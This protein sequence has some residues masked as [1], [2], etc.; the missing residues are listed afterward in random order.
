MEFN[1][2]LKRKPSSLLTPTC[3]VGA[4]VEIPLEQFQQLINDPLGNRDY[5]REHSSAM[6]QDG[7]QYH[8]LLVLSEDTLDGVLIEA[9]GYDH[10]QYGAY[11]SGA[12]LVLKAEL[13]QV[14]DR[15]IYVG[16]EETT[17]GRWL[18]YNNR[19]DIE[20]GLTVSET[21]GI[22]NMLLEKLKQRPE[23]DDATLTDWHI[24]V[25]YHP[26]YCKKLASASAQNE[27]PELHM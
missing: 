22:G 5:I 17:D 11:V 2:D 3:F 25:S 21:N 19:I 18:F 14:A 15:I 20:M 8:C 4:V 27:N 7:D 10:V 26:Q 12:W 1:I 6:W 13:E 23:V 9:E 24:Q 16:T